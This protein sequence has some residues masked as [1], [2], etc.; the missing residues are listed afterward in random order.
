MVF[1]SI[2]FIFIF[3]PLFLVSYYIV[4]GSCRNLHLFLGS[5]F[6]YFIGSINN[7]D[8]T[9]IFIFSLILNFVI[10]RMID[11]YKNKI[12]LIIGIT[13]N[14]LCLSIF[15]Y[16]LNV[17]PIGIS[18]YTF[19]AIAYLCD[20]YGKKSCAEKSFINFGTYLGMFPQLIAGP[21]VKYP[22]IREQIYARKYEIHNIAQGLR[23]FI[24]GLGSKVI[25][26]NQVGMLWKQL[27]TIGYESISTSLAWMGIWAYSF[28]IYFDFWGYSLMAV[29]LGKMLGFNLP[30]NFDY[31]YLSTSMTEFW[32]RWHI[33]LGNW[34]K[35]YVYIP[36]GGN[37]GS[38]LKTYRNLLIVWLL[39]GIWHG[40]NWNFVIWGML[41]FLLIV[42]EKAGFKKLL[43]RHKVFG[44]VYMMVTIPL[45][46]AVFANTEKG[47]MLLFFKR[48]F[49]MEASANYIFEADYIKYGKQY[50]ICLLL[51]ILFCTRIPQKIWRKAE[52]TY[53]GQVILIGIFLGVI[54]CLYIG[55]NNPFLYYRF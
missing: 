6:F 38:K 13:S 30:W 36:L 26:A 28:Q 11:R 43:D 9:M 19:Q 21:I 55:L 22:Y 35:E 54:Y 7:P 12:W 20:V 44:H 24:L 45:S 53:I 10:G 18:F 33:T 29:G 31:P 46:W 50:G 34:F 8:Y 42:L 15:K 40:A 47:Q 14:V 49:G 39:T 52:K 32:H 1:S 41:L 17:L 4:P 25:L 37:R 16:F 3:L 48:L 51:C 2:E 23:T 27:S 5:I